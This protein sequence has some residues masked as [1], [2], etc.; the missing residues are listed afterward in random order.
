VNDLAQSD[1]DIRF[2]YFTF[3]KFE[4]DLPEADDGDCRKLTDAVEK[5]FF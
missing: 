1:C 4:I 5:L 2:C 3:M